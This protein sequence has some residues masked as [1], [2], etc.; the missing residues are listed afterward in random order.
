MHDVDQSV[1][2]V[3][4]ICR[5]SANYTGLNVHVHTITVIIFFQIL[6]QK[7]TVLFYTKDTRVTETQEV[8]KCRGRSTIN[9]YISTDS[10]TFVIK[11][12]NKLEFEM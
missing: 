1:V 9:A 6:V 5:S 11:F 8:E 7:L 4:C 10:E 12:S 2:V 3:K